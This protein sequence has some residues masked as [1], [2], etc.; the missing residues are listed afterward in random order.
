MEA[1]EDKPESAM[2]TIDSPV[3]GVRDRHSR[4]I[5]LLLCGGGKDTGGETEEAEGDPFSAS[6]VLAISEWAERSRTLAQFP[7]PRAVGCD[8]HADS[9]PTFHGHTPVETSLEHWAV[10]GTPLS[11]CGVQVYFLLP[12]SSSCLRRG[13]L[14]P[15]PYVQSL[16]GWLASQWDG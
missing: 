11:V 13:L 14:S 10:G 5:H 2:G 8:W 1:L 6:P 4:L 16:I 9:T 15:T 3:Y 12:S 7:K